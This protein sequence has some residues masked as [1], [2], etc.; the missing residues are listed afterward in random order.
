MDL[1]ERQSNDL[2]LEAM[3]LCNV[4]E[5]LRNAIYVGVCIGG[6]SSYVKDRQLGWQAFMVDV[7]TL[8]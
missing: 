6:E 4:S 7:T 8:T 3:V 5:T 1:T 2:L